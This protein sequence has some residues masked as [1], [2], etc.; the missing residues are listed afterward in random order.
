MYAFMKILINL[1][2][3]YWI[4]LTER[5]GDRVR[6]DFVDSLRWKVKLNEKTSRKP[7]LKENNLAYVEVLREVNK[8]RL[9]MMNKPKSEEAQYKYKTA[10][11]KSNYFGSETY[12]TQG[13]FFHVVGQIQSN[14]KDLNI[15]LNEYVDSFIENIGDVFKEVKHYKKFNTDKDVCYKM[16]IKLSKYLVRALLAVKHLGEKLQNKWLQYKIR[17]DQ[18]DLLLDIR[19][20]IRGKKLSNACDQVSGC[21]NKDEAYKKVQMALN[22]MDIDEC[23][24][25]HDEV[26]DIFIMILNK[27]YMYLPRKIDK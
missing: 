2:K 27:I 7:T 23:S 5:L 17:S 6:D 13:A 18:I 9:E 10:I 1:R 15:S 8:L 20:N 24:K 21:I 12:F 3:K 19:K 26:L 22:N 16:V 4:N 25:F 14:L 11:S